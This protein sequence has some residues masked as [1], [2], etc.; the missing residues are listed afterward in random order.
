MIQS[1]VKG[2]SARHLIAHLDES[3]MLDTDCRHNLHSMND[4]EKSESVQTMRSGVQNFLV[5]ATSPVNDINVLCVDLNLNN[6]PPLVGHLL[7]SALWSVF[8]VHLAC[9]V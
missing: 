6:D 1:T 9:A 8:C 2:V 5:W 7:M 3:G 4:S